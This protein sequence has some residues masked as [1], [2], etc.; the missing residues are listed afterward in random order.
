MLVSSTQQYCKALILIT[1]PCSVVQ[2]VPLGTPLRNRGHLIHLS[3]LRGHSPALAIVQFQKTVVSLIL[4]SFLVV[5]SRTGSQ[6]PVTL[7]LFEAKAQFSSLEMHFHLNTI[8]YFQ[9]LFESLWEHAVRKNEVSPQGIFW[10][11]TVCFLIKSTVSLSL[12]Q[13]RSMELSVMMGMF[14]LWVVHYSNH[15]SHVAVELWNVVNA[16]KEPNFDFFF[17]LIN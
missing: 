13:G 15:Y 7:S 10:V 8:N 9:V 14:S 17:M 4:S 1:P 2:K 11:S 6:I 16:M 12:D 5:Y 3:S